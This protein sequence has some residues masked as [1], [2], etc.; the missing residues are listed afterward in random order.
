MSRSLEVVE[1]AQIRIR[2]EC[3]RCGMC[4]SCAPGEVPAGWLTGWTEM[5]IAPGVTRRR[6][7]DRCG[8]CG[9]TSESG[10]FQPLVASPESEAHASALRKTV[11]VQR[12]R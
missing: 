11:V 9:A 5:I 3:G 10:T 8:A 1:G 7:E 2:F 4:V 6:R 12:R